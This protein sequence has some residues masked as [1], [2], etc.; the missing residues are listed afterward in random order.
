MRREVEG[1]RD[2]A[3]DSRTDG[4]DSEFKA[5]EL[6]VFDKYLG[7]YGIWHHTMFTVSE[8]LGPGFIRSYTLKVLFH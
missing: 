8:Y 7:E 3:A 1:G 2:T 6:K 4:A 5:Y